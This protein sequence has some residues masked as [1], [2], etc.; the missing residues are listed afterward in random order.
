MPDKSIKSD[1]VNI[2]LLFTN[3]FEVPDYQRE[4]IWKTENVVRFIDD[5]FLPFEDANEDGSI[6]REYFIGS[7]VICPTEGEVKSLIDGQQRL[8]TIY[9][10][11]CAIKHSLV[12]LNHSPIPADLT[13]LLASESTDASGQTTRRQR[14]TLQYPES[15]NILK[16]IS[17]GNHYDNNS[18]GVTKNINDAY[19]E[20]RE[21]LSDRLA[22]NA[23][24]ILKFYGYFIHSVSLV[25]VTTEDVGK[26]LQIFETINE[27][28]KGLDAF[29]LLKN[30]IFMEA[31]EA[32]HKSIKDEWE[33][34]TQTIAEMQEKPLRFMRYYIISHYKLDGIFS[35]RKLT[36]ATIFDWFSE[37][38]NLKAVGLKESPVHLVKKFVD[39][40]GIYKGYFRDNQ[41]H[42]K[43]F[44]EWIENLSRLG[45]RAARQHLIVLLAASKFDSIELFNSIAEE[46]EKCLFVA[47]LIKERSQ[48]VES[49]FQNWAIEIQNSNE[50]NQVDLIK[51]KMLEDRKNRLTQFRDAFLNLDDTQIPKYRLKYI[52]AK[53][54]Q[55]IEINAYT[56]IDSTKNLSNYIQG[57]DIEHIYPTHPTR[58]AMKE[59]GD[60]TTPNIANKLGNLLLI[61]NSINQS[62]QNKPYSY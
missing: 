6:A 42:K 50:K 18:K 49:K 55:H 14:L 62:I 20:I 23:N 53:L 11:L 56:R 54:N 51:S 1:V 30:K 9:L 44:N 7:I 28:G 2:K 21:M 35:N 31:D 19:S 52:L 34:L 4:Y 3:F 45:G 59:F 38:S 61:E 15:S 13:H 17:E 58:S 32:Q 40:A 29:D 24:R 37:E 60:T 46:L 57:C 47:L 16:N 26:A 10:V 43:N 5:I 33:I 48:M 27:R 12:E 36:E 41:D 39:A 25:Q 22:N 8:T